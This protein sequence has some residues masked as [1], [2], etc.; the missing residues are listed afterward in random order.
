[1]IVLSRTSVHTSD[2][3]RLASDERR[4]IRLALGPSGL[5]F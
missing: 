4:P 5:Q 2:G 1:M 3:Y